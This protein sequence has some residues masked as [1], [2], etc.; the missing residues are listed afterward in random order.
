MKQ[1]FEVA[2]TQAG[3]PD[4]GIDAPG[5][6]RNLFLAAAIV[7]AVAIFFPSVRVGSVTFITHP[8]AWTFAPWLALGGVLMLIYVKWGKFRHRDRMLSL[9]RWTGAET[10]L[11]V[12]TGRGLLM[13]GAARKLTTGRSFGID[14]WSAKDLSGN[15]PE[16]AIRNAELEGVADRIEVRSEDATRM[17]FPDASFDVVLTNVC[18]HNIPT[19]EGRAQACR[20]IARVLKPGGVALVS[21]FIHL[22]EYA[23]SFRQTGAQAERAGW[24]FFDTFPPM[25]I[26]RVRKPGSIGDLA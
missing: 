2:N 10:V 8:M 17:T 13:I 6:I 24:F 9:V 18:I 15:R 7:F 5:V 19:R 3:K 20:E 22:G 16:G 21:D 26:L 25:R 11:D 4:Y 12:G 1:A 14:I 23:K